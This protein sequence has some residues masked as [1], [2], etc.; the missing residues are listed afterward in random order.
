[1]IPDLSDCVGSVI[2]NPGLQDSQALSISSR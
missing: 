2:F 1:M